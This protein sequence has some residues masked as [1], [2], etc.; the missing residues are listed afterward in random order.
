MAWSEED[1]EQAQLVRWFRSQHPELSDL[2]WATPNGDLR[3]KTVAAR[4]KAT[5]LL[6]GVPDLFLAVAKKG[7]HGL[8]IEMKRPIVPG[9]R[10]AYPT[11]NQRRIIA[12]LQSQGYK[13]FV[14]YGQV[15]AQA[16]IINYLN[17][18]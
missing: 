18:A 7:A 3:H 11:K 12:A 6:S 2:F 10:K 4:L 17:S 16:A 14:C 1:W 5:G 9:R 15:E 13:A 8:F